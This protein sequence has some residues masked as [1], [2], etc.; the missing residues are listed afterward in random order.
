MYNYFKKESADFARCRVLNAALN[1]CNNISRDYYDVE[2]PPKMLID[3]RLS[4]MDI[5]YMVKQLY[6]P[7]EHHEAEP[8]DRYRID[9]LDEEEDEVD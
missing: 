6:P 4:Q 5:D 3:S 9:M 8:V 7:E 1:H 2:Y